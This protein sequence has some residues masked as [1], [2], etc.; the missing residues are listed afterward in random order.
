MITIKMQPNST[1]VYSLIQLNTDDCLLVDNYQVD[2]E[3]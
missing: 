3:I 2:N 1:V